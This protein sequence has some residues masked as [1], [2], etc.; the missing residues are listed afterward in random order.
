MTAGRT[1]H[2]KFAAAEAECEHNFVLHSDWE[3]DPSIPNGT[4]TFYWMECSKCNEEREATREDHRQNTLDC[5][6]AEVDMYL[7][8]MDWN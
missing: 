2:T 1:N 3:G 7:A 6:Q 8:N 4:N 5:Q